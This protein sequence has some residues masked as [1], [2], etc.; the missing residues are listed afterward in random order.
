MVDGVPFDVKGATFGHDHDIENFN[1]Y[2]KDLQFLGVNTIRIWGTNDDTI[3]L[4]DAAHKYN[5][6]VLMGIWMRHGKPGMEGDD[7][8]NYLEDTKGMEAIYKEAIEVV[9]KYKNHPAVL[10]WG[11]GNEVYLNI[12]TDP[13]KEAY[14]KLLE[15]ICS[16]IKTLDPNHPLPLLK[17]GLLEWIGGTN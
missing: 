12:A 5:I 14:S 6:K 3:K 4:L 2:F 10:S 16:K 17:L 8:F 15:R 7:N 9:E 13:E 11:V 1:S